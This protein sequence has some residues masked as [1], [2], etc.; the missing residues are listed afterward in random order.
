MKEGEHAS[1]YGSLHDQGIYSNLINLFFL[2]LFDFC[3]VI[4]TTK[5]YLKFQFLTSLRLLLYFPFMFLNFTGLSDSSQ[6][7]DRTRAHKFCPREVFMTALIDP[8]Q[9]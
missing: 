7:A 8:E 3:L 6:F 4:F 9:W 1:L 5:L 2:K